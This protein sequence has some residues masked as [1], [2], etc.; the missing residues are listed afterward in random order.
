VCVCAFSL[1]ELG[2]R[3]WIC[4]LYN[5]NGT[6]GVQREGIIGLKN[7]NVR[8]CDIA[9]VS[10]LLSSKIFA[11]NWIK[12]CAHNIKQLFINK[13]RVLRAAFNKENTT[14]SGA[15]LSLLE[16]ARMEIILKILCRRR[17]VCMM[18]R[19]TGDRKLTSCAWIES[20]QS[21]LF[22]IRLFVFT[23]NGLAKRMRDFS[24][25]EHLHLNE[26]WENLL[27]WII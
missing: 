5:N 10:C 22:W 19:F 16:H 20:S 26:S 14:Q 4:T 8:A 15:N 12:L 21:E 2:S 3:H 7:L 23:L 13:F 17:C 9:R 1:T 25:P 27:C 11:F 24:T 6:A 18:M